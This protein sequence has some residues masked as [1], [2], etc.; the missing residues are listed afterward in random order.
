MPIEGLI[1]HPKAIA[2]TSAGTGI[3]WTIATHFWRSEC[4][5]LPTFDEGLRTIARAHKPTWVSH[6]ADIKAIL[7]EIIPDLAKAFALYQNRRSVLLAVGQKGH[8]ATRLKALAKAHAQRNHLPDTAYS[9]TIAETNRAMKR[10]PLP[11]SQG[12]QEA[13]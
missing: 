11:A 9:P 3:L 1:D 4:A 8:S 5:P 12:F 13:A 7:S 2:L 6:R 10:A